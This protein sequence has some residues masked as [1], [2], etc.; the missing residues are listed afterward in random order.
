[1]GRK[2][3]RPPWFLLTSANSETPISF[4]FARLPTGVLSWPKTTDIRRFLCTPIS[5]WCSKYW[6][7]GPRLGLI[8]GKLAKTQ[9]NTGE[10][11]QDSAKYWGIGPRL[12]SYFT[13]Y[14]ELH[15]IESA[16][17]SHK[18]VNTPQTWLSIKKERGFRERLSHAFYAPS[19]NQKP[20][21]YIWEHFDMIMKYPPTLCFH[22]RLAFVRKID[23]DIPNLLFIYL[24][25]RQ[26]AHPSS[27]PIVNYTTSSPSRKS[28]NIYIYKHLTWYMR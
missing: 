10:L 3:K 13:A 23:I 16:S 18:Y 21:S 15:G 20:L 8:L 17:K 27:P 22:A 12:S 7:I 4:C 11:G 14:S 5:E 19:A 2:E 25:L 24:R 26:H 1:M 28:T 6:G 9:L